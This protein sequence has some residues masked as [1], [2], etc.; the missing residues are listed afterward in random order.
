MSHQTKGY[1]EYKVTTQG[2]RRFYGA[3]RLFSNGPLGK[4]VMLPSYI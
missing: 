1:T 2:L 4:A 3:N